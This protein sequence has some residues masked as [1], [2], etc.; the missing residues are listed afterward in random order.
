MSK[1]EDSEV[2]KQGELL[3]ATYVHRGSKT[4]LD[5]WMQNWLPEY[6]LN[7]K[8]QKI[9]EIYEAANYTLE[10]IEEILEKA[11]CGL[12]YIYKAKRGDFA[13]RLYYAA[14]PQKVYTRLLTLLAVR[15][16]M[17]EK[18]TQGQSPRTQGHTP[19]DIVS[20]L[21]PIFY[22]KEEDVRQF[23]NEIRGM[24]TEDITELVNQ[25]VK[26]KRISDYGNS[27]KGVL[28]EILHNAGLY[29]KSRSNWNGRV[30]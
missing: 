29:S 17:I 7:V 20:K 11:P 2:R 28:W 3:L 16:V 24:A 30:K 27:R 6:F 25:W 1:M 10:M 13:K 15:E 4:Q 14:L 5:W 18:R 12:F 23:L 19:C 8:E 26:E 21:L 22:N 9:V